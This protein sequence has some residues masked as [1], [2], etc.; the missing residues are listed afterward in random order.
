[1][2]E[3]AKSEIIDAKAT[4]VTLEESLVKALTPADDADDRSVVLEVR[5]GTG[6]KY[7]LSVVMI[8]I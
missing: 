2:V 1:M 3:L 4:L 7:L 8:H 5:A 6:E